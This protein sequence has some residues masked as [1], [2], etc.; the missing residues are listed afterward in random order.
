MLLQTLAAAVLAAPALA[1]DPLLGKPVFNNPAGTETQQYAIFQ[2]LARVIDHVPA[3]ETIALSWFGFDASYTDTDTRPNI[4]DRLVRAKKRGVQV[5][6]VLDNNKLKNS[7]AYP[8]K[9]L[10]PVLGTDD[11]AKSF[12]VLCPDKKGCI[13]KRKI[14]AD[15]TAYN[16]NK[17]LIAS[18]IVLDSG[19]NVSDVVFQSS[20]N[21]GT[22][23]AD[24][25]WNNAIT[26]SETSS[27]KNYQR[28]FNDL[29]VNHDGKGVENYYW[30][31]KSADK[32]KT[33]FFPRKE[34]NG[35]LNQASTD[36]IVSALNA[37]KCSYKDSK[38]NTHQTDVRVV[39]WAFTRV[40]V[41]NKLAALVRAGCWVDVVYTAGNDNESVVKALKNTGGKK[42]GVTRCSVPYKGRKLRPHSKIM[43]IDGAYDD[44]QVPRIFMGSHN[45]AMSALRNADES[46]V[47][48]RDGAVHAEY[49]HNFYAVRDTCSGKTPPK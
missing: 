8:Y 21:L 29:R 6:V 3:G 45:Y 24:T 19:K 44:D 26:W 41:A 43:L 48:I 14:Y 9:T 32:Y 23:D 10:A 16:H 34:T 47:R 13:A 28:Y 15:T 31:G 42:I 5:R 1:A 33:H 22:W 46:L 39:M 38:G 17:F 35:D 27:Y 36:T 49:L 4:A 25:A 18:R 30:I 11:A 37:V 7:K 20:S 40:A 12:I 2:Q